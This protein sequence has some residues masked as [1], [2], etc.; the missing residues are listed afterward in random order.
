MV[1]LICS[2]SIMIFCNLLTNPFLYTRYFNTSFF[3]THTNLKGFFV[4]K[5]CCRISHKQLYA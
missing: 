3:T 2:L 4:L 5:N 1:L